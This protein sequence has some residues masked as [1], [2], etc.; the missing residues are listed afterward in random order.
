MEIVWKANLCF[1]YLDHHRVAQCRSKAWCKHCRGKHHSSLCE[2]VTDKDRD[3]QTKQDSTPQPDKK[4]SSEDIT[5]P[6]TVSIPPKSPETNML[7]KNAAA[8]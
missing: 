5:A 7:P 3:K 6:L 8:F 2:T 1:N 4:P